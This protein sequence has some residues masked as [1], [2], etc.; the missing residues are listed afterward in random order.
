MIPRQHF[1]NKIRDLNYSYKKRAK[2]VDLYKK[3]GATHRIFLPQVKQ[4][5]DEF[6]KSSLKQAGCGEEEINAFIASCRV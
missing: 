2:R 1:L 5:E 6:V 4:L 3:Q